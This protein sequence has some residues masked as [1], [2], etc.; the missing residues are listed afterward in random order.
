MSQI[1][2]SAIKAAV[3]SPGLNSALSKN[4]L[5]FCFFFFFPNDHSLWMWTFLLCLDICKYFEASVCWLPLC[6]NSAYWGQVPSGCL[7]C[8]PDSWA[9]STRM[10]LSQRILMQLDPICTYSCLLNFS[11]QR[12]LLI[13]SELNMLILQ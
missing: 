9:S 8:A 12:I 13:I 1:L 2:G 6:L 7:S 3:V 4:L 11:L 5:L 10:L